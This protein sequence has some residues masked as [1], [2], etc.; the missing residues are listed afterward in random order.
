[1]NNK[2]IMAGLVTAGVVT[3]VG[4]NQQADACGLGDVKF[5]VTAS[6]LN[7]RNGAG[8]NN[9][10][11]GSVKKGQ[12]FTPD[13]VSDDGAWVRIKVNGRHGWVNKQYMK[14]IDECNI[15]NNEQA[16]NKVDNTIYDAITTT[17]LNVRTDAT[18]ASA[19]ITTL[20]KGSKVTV[21]YTVNGWANVEYGHRK[22]GF[23]S[24][25]YLQ[26]IGSNQGTL[27]STV[28]SAN[29]KIINN[30]LNVRTGVSLT[31]SVVGVAPKGTKVRILEKSKS[32]PS[33]VKISYDRAG[34]TF[35]GWVS[36]KYM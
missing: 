4:F 22:S 35:T 36:A 14:S 9:L 16:S 19:K 10:V 32:D 31:S 30:N 21:N 28:N 1:M 6:S 20:N 17:A 27:N 15:P 8:L 7:V 25:D 24:V 12:I 29:T 34:R 11:I 2:M 26:K 3:A 33:R 5:Q 18:T 13:R 23:V